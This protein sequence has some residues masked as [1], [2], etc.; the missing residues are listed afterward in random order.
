MEQED[1]KM[2][3]ELIALSLMMFNEV[4]MDDEDDTFKI[5][6]NK[7]KSGVKEKINI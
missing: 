7:Q 3:M 6:Y 2:D 5:N 4:I 1:I